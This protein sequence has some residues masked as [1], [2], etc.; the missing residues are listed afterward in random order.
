MSLLDLIRNRLV[1]HL[2]GS[3]KTAVINEL[4]DFLVREGEV[5]PDQRAVVERA[6]FG[7]EQFMSTGMEQ[8]IAL[9]HGVTDAIPDEVAAIGI[10]QAG[11]SFECFDGYPAK[12]II[13][14]LTPTNKAL[15]RVSTLAQIVRVINRSD[16]RKRI[17]AATTPE[18]VVAAIQTL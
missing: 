3:D 10:S 12:I 15:I 16:V 8:G 11:V 4:I 13:L 17:L 9:P 6:V 14:L 7:R 5:Q 18:K 1:C 2:V